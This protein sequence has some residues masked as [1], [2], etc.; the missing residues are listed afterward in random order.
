M[1]EL[2]NEMLKLYGELERTSDPNKR[3]ELQCEIE[4]LKELR[5]EGGFA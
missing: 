3:W 4:R 2:R 5:K 1:E